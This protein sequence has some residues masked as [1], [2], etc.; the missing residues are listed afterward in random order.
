MTQANFQKIIDGQLKNKPA[1]KR[2]F[3]KHSS[4]KKRSTGRCTVECKRCGRRA[5]HIGNYGLDLCR[6][7]FREIAKKI[8]FVQYS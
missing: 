7:C 6:Q 1:K 5:A 2:R 8:G 3:L 4:P